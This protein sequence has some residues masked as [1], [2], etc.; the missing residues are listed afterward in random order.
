MWTCAAA[1]GAGHALKALENCGCTLS[2]HALGSTAAPGAKRLLRQLAAAREHALQ[3]A[4]LTLKVA[5]G[6]VA[7]GARR[8]GPRALKQLHLVAVGQQLR[9]AAR[10]LVVNLRQPARKQ[11]FAATFDLTE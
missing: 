7:D 10:V 9:R 1:S 3:Q 8:R 2:D 5:A 4:A 6:G 11:A